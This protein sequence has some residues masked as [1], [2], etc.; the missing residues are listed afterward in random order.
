MKHFFS[1]SAIITSLA[2]VGIVSVFFTTQN[3]FPYIQK[4]NAAELAFTSILRFGDSNNDV[5]R[6]QQFLNQDSGTR[7]AS[8][9]P[10]SSG[11]ETDYFGP[12]TRRAVIKFQEKYAVE[13]LH[14]VG[15]T[16]GSGFVGSFTLAKI[17]SLV[18]SKKT[19]V[20]PTVTYP[21]ISIIPRVDSVNPNRVRRGEVV[22]VRGENFLASGNTV[23]LRYGLIEARFQNVASVDGKT[24]EFVFIP[25]DVLTMSKEEIQSLP[26]NI[27]DDLLRPVEALGGSI[28]D[29]V[30]PYRGIKSETQL[31]S[32]MTKNGRHFDSLYDEFYVT[33]E[34]KNGRGHSKGPILAGLSKVHFYEKTPSK[35]T[36]LGPIMSSLQSVVAPSVYAQGIT[37][38]GY[39]SGI[40]MY[41]TCGGG[42]LT[43]MTDISGGGGTG[44]YH[45]AAGYIP[46]VGTG[47][48]AAPQLGF[49]RQNGGSC[50][51]YVGTACTSITSNAPQ[52]PWG[53]AL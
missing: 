8:F 28:E 24:M 29:I 6:L 15:L 30:N 1:R 9:G 4:V 32:I 25:P 2:C 39:N 41:C 33:V 12:A 5:L 10:G 17:N 26:Q 20:S 27:Y 53:A 48:V 16:S 13:V 45:F 51:I 22:T 7:V 46:T 38:G 49:Y 47:L 23:R 11:Y 31:A 18:S 52:N 14:P 21:P 40:I 44:L 34:N 37:L 3:F 35:K 42:F 19:A 50:S 43:F 36:P